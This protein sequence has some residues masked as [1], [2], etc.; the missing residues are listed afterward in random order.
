MKTG[1]SV[2]RGDVVKIQRK[3][4]TIG[5]GT[6]IVLSLPLYVTIAK[7]LRI[8]QF[9][10]IE[11]EI[12]QSNASLNW[13]LVDGNYSVRLSG[14][15]ASNQSV[16]SISTILKELPTGF[17]LVGPGEA[18]LFHVC[19]DGSR[20]CD[21]GFATLLQLPIEFLFING[22]DITDQTAAIIAGH[23]TLIWLNLHDVSVSEDAFRL[24]REQ[25]PG[26]RITPESNAK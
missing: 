16:K 10:A 1:S 4:V 23:R 18:R 11:A 25:N 6:L 15:A 20:V 5:V 8:Q 13:E 17:T 12:G 24:I 14:H 7:Q 26:L 19:L 9:K 2:V 3:H 21:D 22:G